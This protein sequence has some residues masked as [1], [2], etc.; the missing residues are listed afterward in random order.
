MNKISE[1]FEANYLTRRHF[2]LF[3]D[4]L[5]ITA[6]DAHF[7]KGIHKIKLNIIN[8]EFSE[9]HSRSQGFSTGLYLLIISL[10]FYYGTIFGPKKDAVVCLMSLI[11]GLIF[12]LFFLKRLKIARFLNTSGVVAFDIIKRGKSQNQFEDFVAKIV[13]QINLSKS[14]NKS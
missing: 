10:I 8:P 11:F 13:N 2:E 14:N 12:F 4:E 3:D 1:Y 5:I 7:N 6:K 9:I